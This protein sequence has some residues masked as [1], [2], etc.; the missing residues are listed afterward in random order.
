MREIFTMVFFLIIM[1]LTGSAVL[2]YFSPRAI[3]K[4]V[5]ILL[6]SLI[7]PI[8][9]NMV[10]VMSEQRIPAAGGS[11]VFLMGMS[12]AMMALLRFTLEYCEISKKYRKL[13]LIAHTLLILDIIQL[14]LNPYFHHAFEVEEILVDGLPYF[15]LIPHIGQTV[16]RIIL[17]GVLA[18]VLVIFL[19]KVIRTPR[20]YSE[21]YSVIL[22]TVVAAAVWESV[23][24][25]SRTPIDTSMIGLGIIGLL[26]YYFS[27]Y[28]RPMRLLDR[29]LANIA[30]Q[31]T[32][33]LFF[34]DM[35]GR[36]IWANPRGHALTH[37]KERTIDSTAEKLEE[38]IGEFKVD[39]EDWTDQRII[40][41]NGMEKY[42]ELEMHT[43]SDDHFRTAGCVL[44]VRDNTEEI[45][46][47]KREFYTATHDSLTGLYTREYLHTCILQ[48]L[49]CNPGIAY[50]VVFV[51]VKNFKIVNDIFSTMFGDFA[52]QCI[53]Q[54]I[55]NGMS[56][57]CVYGRL[58]GD[59]FGVLM[60]VDEFNAEKL[61]YEL[62]PFV[63]REGTIEYHILI[64]LGVYRITEPGLQVS[65]MFDRAHLALSTI[66][67]EY[68]THIAYYDDELRSKVLW[69]QYI[70]S[71]IHDAIRE[72]Q[73]RP[74]LQPIVDQ[75]GKVVGA[76]AL[77]RW[78]HPTDGFMS[79]GAFIPVFEQ[80]G[81]IVEIDRHMWR[82]ACEILAGWQANN[83]DLFLSVNISP[84][85]FYFIDVLAEIKS[86]V[87]EHHILP[88]RLR[89]EITETVM[90][91]DSENRMDIL[92]Q[93]REAG[94]IVEMDDFG[95]GYSSLNMLKDMPVDVLKL[96]MKFLSKANNEARSQTIV[97]NVI[98][99]SD[100]L[101]ITSL[102]EGVETEAQY[103]MLAEMQC[104][105]FQ[106]YYFS[107]PLPVEDFEA[108]C[109]KANET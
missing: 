60:P 51:N 50:Q 8:A 104:S 91:N 81:L 21:R 108:F 72:R 46:R 14:I 20:I 2:A 31:M 57:N 65:V 79:P 32:E 61:E 55:K 90:M 43:V 26:I 66:R 98:H 58:G 40:N 29:M 78:I 62:S 76:E 56:P 9:G 41:V 89:I 106:G 77:A 67:D 96:D 64:H 28:Y 33:A 74:Y 34:F 7:P 36:C 16:H 10:I 52:L 93:F 13:R 101:G 48:K 69:D 97:Q 86:L 109:A 4:S 92:N 25:F 45:L 47:R 70:T 99:L 63:V 84:K 37:T 22:F 103:K 24:I 87:E 17:Y 27:L 39:I 105:L 12:L 95:S 15:R 23:Y 30:S 54:W 19:V 38:L 83:R 5:A 73:I 71:Q 80:N 6:A 11:V 53:A 35:N 94:F 49:S 68:Q 75:N 82:C 18:T 102:T 1:A 59:T 107:K 85:D 88:E 3:G 44:T 100:D 42:Y